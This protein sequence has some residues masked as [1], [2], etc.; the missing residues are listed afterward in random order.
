MSQGD[1]VLLL[2]ESRCQLGE[3]L[4]LCRSSVGRLAYAETSLRCKAPHAAPARARAGKVGPYV[5]PQLGPFA[6]QISFAPV[7]L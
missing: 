1:N 3:N 7:L 6:M 5:E 2:C 4:A